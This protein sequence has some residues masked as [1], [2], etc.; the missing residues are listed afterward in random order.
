ME[1][2]V[3][4]KISGKSGVGSTGSCR[5]CSGDRI[6]IVQ[7]INSNH[8]TRLVATEME[9]GGQMHDTGLLG[10]ITDLGDKFPW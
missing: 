8:L 7:E 10:L 5:D 6:A 3:R 2:A 1:R 9:K 4:K